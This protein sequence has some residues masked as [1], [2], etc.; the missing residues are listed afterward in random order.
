MMQSQK[1]CLIGT[2]HHPCERQEGAINHWICVPFC[3]FSQRGFLFAPV[4]GDREQMHV[5]T[6][7]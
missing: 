3:A 2:P 5:R 6:V 1:N 4:Q 7:E